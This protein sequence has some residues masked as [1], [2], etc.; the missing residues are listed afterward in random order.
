[1]QTDKIEILKELITRFGNPEAAKFAKTS[2]F[3][4]DRHSKALYPE[5]HNAYKIRLPHFKILTAIESDSA[6]I[7]PIDE[8]KACLG[9][10]RRRIWLYILSCLPDDLGVRIDTVILQD[11]RNGQGFVR[12]VEDIVI[13]RL[14]R[15]RGISDPELATRILDET[16]FLEFARNWFTRDKRASALRTLRPDPFELKMK[17]KNKI[18]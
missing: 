6:C 16:R 10:V 7:D 8:M 9:V 1:M 18:K 5:S 12:G 4:S 15:R 3:I 17:H 2:A 13:A 14:N 11:Q